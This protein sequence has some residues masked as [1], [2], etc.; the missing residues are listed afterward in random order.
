MLNKSSTTALEKGQRSTLEDKDW[1]GR[2]KT[3]T[4]ILLLIPGAF[5]LFVP[6]IRYISYILVILG[7]AYIYVGNYFFRESRK[8][9]PLFLMGGFILAVSV[10]ELLIVDISGSAAA[11]MSGTYQ[12]SVETRW[13]TVD[14]SWLMAFAAIDIVLIF[15]IFTILMERLF[16]IPGKAVLVIALSLSALIAIFVFANTTARASELLSL[17]TTGKT[18]SI[19]AAGQLKQYFTGTLH[20]FIIPGAIVAMD[21]LYGILK[22]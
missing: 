12:I 11:V 18:T 4:G 6:Y 2:A 3:V 9:L 16:T 19:A 5:L 10:L 1:P 13:F 7:M 17:V 20:F 15:S 14:F 22:N 8:A 21:L